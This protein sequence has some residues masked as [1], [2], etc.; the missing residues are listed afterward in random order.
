MKITKI[1][2]KNYR[3]IKDITLGIKPLFGLIG[4]NSAGKSNIL[5]ALN[6]VLGEKYP[7]PH[8]LEK[9]DFHNER[10]SNN[11]EISILFDDVFRSYG[12]DCNEILFK[13][14]YD[15]DDGSFCTE[16][17]AIDC[18][19]HEPQKWNIKGEAREQFSV[20][21]IPASRNFDYHLASHTKW[22]LLGKIINQFD[23]IFPSE[24]IS[25]LSEKF[26]EV[27]F[28]LETEKFKEFEKTF[29]NAFFE[30][31]LPTENEVDIGFKAFDPKSYY[32]TIEIIP[33]EYGIIKDMDQMGEG[34]KN[35]VLLS[36][37]RAYADT[38]PETGIFLIEEPE[39]YLHPQGRMDLFNVYKDLAEKGSQ[40]IYATHSQE[41]IDIENFGNIGVVRKIREGD[42]H[43]TKVFTINE[44]EFLK[45]WQDNTGVA[46]ASVD[47]IK[48]F[49]KNIS[50]AE[51][52]KGFFAKKVVLVE[53]QTEKWLLSIYMKKLGVEVEK[54][55]IEVINVC[56]K[57]NIEKFYLIF[58]E[59]E[60]KIYV[61]FDGDKSEGESEEINKKLMKMF[62][63]NE[64]P[65]P[66]SKIEENYAVFEENIENELQNS[67]KNYEELKT[68]AKNM[69]GLKANRN[70]EIIAKYIANNT[71]PPNFIKQIVWYI[72][73]LQHTT[74]TL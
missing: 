56:G 4:A 34:L 49:L 42:D 58:S 39:L 9:K 16:L 70:K 21:H 23:N 72:E 69:Y 65:W 11:I 17:R 2:I 57:N 28:H 36:L 68:E 31:K 61:I 54:Q 14:I 53:G 33:K 52:N 62:S 12:R 46:E 67:I 50:D 19:T 59:L 1:S 63:K 18:E 64:E 7:M 55:N 30:H 44:K 51:T 20:I 32:K 22:S 66:I 6:F 29:K 13:T 3:S 27:K 41:L 47:S 24:K 40:I 37:F 26:D 73:H 60:Y 8:Y 15:E 38:F 43:H 10:I 25:I 74:N 48:L 71:T 5:R 35:L 45:K